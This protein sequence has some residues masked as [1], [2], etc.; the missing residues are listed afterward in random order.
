MSDDSAPQ[1]TAGLRPVRRV[2]LTV[3]S[4]AAFLCAV[5]ISPIFMLVVGM[6]FDAPGASWSLLHLPVVAF[7]FLMVALSISAGMAVF[8]NKVAPVRWL[9]ALIVGDGAFL[10]AILWIAIKQQAG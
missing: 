10:A 7:P 4:V 6:S 5:A 8:N 2:I 1:Q 9:L 3:I